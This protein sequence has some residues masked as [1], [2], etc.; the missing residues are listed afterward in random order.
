M[1]GIIINEAARKNAELET[2]LSINNRLFEKN[3]I[4]EEMHRK[5]IE[6]LLKQYSEKTNHQNKNRS[7][8]YE[9]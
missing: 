8:D 3:I 2:K 7:S 4:S 5:A 1:N 6:I 9:R